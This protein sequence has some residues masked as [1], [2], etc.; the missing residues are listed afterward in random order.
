VVKEWVYKNSLSVEKVNFDLFQ[1]F[2]D[3]C[4]LS[5]SNNQVL[6][7]DNIWAACKR[8]SEDITEQQS[9]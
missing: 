4:A 5:G 6:V 2:K 7:E 8:I 3:F 1:S 9:Q